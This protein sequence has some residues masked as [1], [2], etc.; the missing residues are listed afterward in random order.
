MKRCEGAD[1][2]ERTWRESVP[3]ENTE[4]GDEGQ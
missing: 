1:E 3:E 4:Q 2:R